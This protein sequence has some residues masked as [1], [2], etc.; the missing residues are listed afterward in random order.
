MDSPSVLGLSVFVVRHQVGQI[1]SGIIKRV[2]A[3]RAVSLPS[4]QAD[5]ADR[6]PRLA[7]ARLR[8]TLLSRVE[9]QSPICPFFNFANFQMMQL[10]TKSST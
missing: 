10:E 2:V 4:G 8:K 7:G 9:P 5:L 6:Q 1:G 3:R